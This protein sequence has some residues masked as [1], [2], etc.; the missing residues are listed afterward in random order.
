MKAVRIHQFGGPEVLQY[1][2]EVPYPS[3]GKGELLIKVA[4]AGVNYADLGRRMGTYPGSQPPAT[5]GLEA[6]GDR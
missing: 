6:A 5:L 2:E 4:A 1:E 3:P